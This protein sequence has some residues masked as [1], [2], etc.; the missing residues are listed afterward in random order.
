MR[1]LLQPAFIL[2]HRPYRETSALLDVLTADYGRI[3]LVAKGIHT[4]RSRLRP[5]IQPFTPL[6]V[7]W[8]GKGELMT[9]HSAE[10]NGAPLMLKGN[11]LL[12]GFYLNELLVKVLQ[13]QDPHPRL[14]TIYHHTLLELQGSNLR[15]NSLRLFEKNLLA[16]LGYGLQLTHDFRTGTAITEEGFYHYYPEHGFEQV[17]ESSKM[18][19]TGKSLLALANEQLDA[20]EILLEIKRLMRLA[21]AS[22]LGY[23]PLQ[24]RKLF[25]VER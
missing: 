19:F 3:A 7:S 2:H 15:Q 20:P 12:S 16:E 5:I 25:G 4:S 18:T 13:K 24:S 23:Q 14:Y 11:C 1:I 6:L 17:A 10:A 22:L 21:L 9:M 8:G